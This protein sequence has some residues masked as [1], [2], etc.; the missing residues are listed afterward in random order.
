MFLD[1]SKLGLELSNPFNICCFPD[2]I[3][4][5]LFVIASQI[6]T[7]LTLESPSMCRLVLKGNV[8]MDARA[9]KLSFFLTLS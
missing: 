4:Q 2:N 8:F 7:V 3:R 9:F 5:Q 6:S 1:I